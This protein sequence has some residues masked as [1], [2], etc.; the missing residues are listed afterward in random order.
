MILNS[1]S[2]RKIF[3]ISSS[4]DDGA[5]EGNK[6]ESEI[7]P[8]GFLKEARK[9]ELNKKATQ[10]F[11]HEHFSLNLTLDRDGLNFFLFIDFFPSFI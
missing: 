1:E 3:S 8:M 10:A 11:A 2:L 7:L 4:D 9:R 5:E 6:K